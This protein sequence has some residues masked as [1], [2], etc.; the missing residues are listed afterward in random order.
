MDEDL[1][2]KH[3]T[4]ELCIKLS[5]TSGIFFKVRHYCPLLYGLSVSITPC[6]LRFSVM[7]LQYGGLTLLIPGFFDPCSIGGG[8]KVPPSVKSPILQI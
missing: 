6:F 1:S 8:H 7:A 3:H 5:R 4:A 2:W